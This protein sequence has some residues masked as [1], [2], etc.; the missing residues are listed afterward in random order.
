MEEVLSGFS[1]HSFDLFLFI[2]GARYCLQLSSDACGCPGP[3]IMSAEVSRWGLLVL[4][5]YLLSMECM[6]VGVAS[7]CKHE[8]SP[9]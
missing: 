4:R 8:A 3:V 5:C 7:Q 6:V 9:S 1:F 2:A